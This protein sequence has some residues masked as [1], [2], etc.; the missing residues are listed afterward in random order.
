LPG[1]GSFAKQRNRRGRQLGRVLTSRYEEVVVDRLFPGTTQLTAALQPLI[2][3]AEQTLRLDQAKRS[4]TIV[5]LDS[6][7]GSVDD[8]NWLLSRGRPGCM[9]K[10]TRAVMPVTWLTACS[11]GSMIPTWR[12][13]QWAV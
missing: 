2:E 11:S 8:V 1:I 6:G 4:R 13:G 7:G 12:V 3:A 5:R 10:T 9:G